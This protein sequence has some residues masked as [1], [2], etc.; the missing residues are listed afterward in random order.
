MY[1][2][3]FQ[4]YVWMNVTWT[5]RTNIS[6]VTHMVFMCAVSL[7]RL[8][9]HVYHKQ[10]THNKRISVS[11]SDFSFSSISTWINT[12]R[13]NNNHIDLMQEYICTRNAGWVLFKFYV[14]ILERS[15]P[16]GI[17][18]YGRISR[19]SCWINRWNIFKNQRFH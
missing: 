13:N 18:R 14:K 1:R 8:F 12:P 19:E 15:F 3:S 10:H 9:L 16:I 4:D 6:N 7:V 5:L 17:V 2:N 11:F